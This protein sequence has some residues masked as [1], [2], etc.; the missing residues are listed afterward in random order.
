MD[1][2]FEHYEGRGLYIDAVLKK[3]IHKTALPEDIQNYC[4]GGEKLSYILSTIIEKNDLSGNCLMMLPFGGPGSMTA[5]F[6]S[7]GIPTIAGDINYKQ[8]G[9]YSP[10]NYVGE[11]HEKYSEKFGISDIAPY[12]FVRWDARNLSLAK[13]SQDL[14][15]CNPPYGV[16]CT[17][18]SDGERGNLQLAIKTA[19]E[20]GSILKTG[21]VAYYVFPQSW[22]DEFSDKINKTPFSIETISDN[23]STAQNTSLPLGLLRLSKSST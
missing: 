22:I 17:L 15:L 14:A 3:N 13:N 11:H 1:R 6:S 21:G 19:K 8:D 2:L 18:G 5:F 16:E 23:I 20:L 7:L 9:S 10:N 12:I 4:L